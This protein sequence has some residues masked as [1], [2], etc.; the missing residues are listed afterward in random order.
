MR[1]PRT[2][3]KHDDSTE[4]VFTDAKRELPPVMAPNPTSAGMTCGR[5]GSKNEFRLRE[6]TMDF[7]RSLLRY[8]ISIMV[9]AIA[10]ILLAAPALSHAQGLA[11]ING[12]VTDPTGAVIPGAQAVLTDTA[13]SKVSHAASNGSGEYTFPALPP[14]N[15]T[16]K[17]TAAGFNGYTQANIHLEADQAVTINATLKPGSGGETVEVTAAPPQVDVTTGTLSQVISNHQ[18]NELPIN[19][20]NAASLTTLAAGVTTAPSGASDQGNTKTFPVV[21]NISVNGTRA[22]QT[23]YL[24]DGGNNLDEYTNVNAPFPFPDALQEFSIQT[25]NFAAEYGQSAGGV[26][27]IITKS[28]TSAYHGNVFEYVRNAVFNAHNYFSF[29]TNSN[30]TLVPYVDPLKRNQFGGTFGG[31]VGI[32]H[33]WKLN[34]GFFF[35]GYQ[36]TSIRDQAATVATST[37]PTTANTAGQFTFT[38]S[39]A[40][41]AANSCI[42]DPFTA[43]NPCF[44]Y[45]FSSGTTYTSTIPTSRFD[46]ASLKMLHYI[47]VTGSTAFAFK[48]PTSQDMDEGVGRYDQDLGDHDHLAA[49]YFLDK[50]HNQGVLDLTNLLTYADTSD[51]TYQNALVSEDHTFTPHV[52]NNLILSYQRE[53]AVRGPAGNGIDV[54]DFGV[55]IWQPANKSIQNIGVS[56]YFSIGDNPYAVFKRSN[57]TLADDVHWVK[58][59]HSF[60]FG[61]HGELGRVD[62]VNQNGQPGTFSFNAN[63]T[64]SAIASFF[65]G[66]VYETKQSS[67]QYQQNRGKYFG[68]YAQD[69]WK[70]N[71]RLTLDY[72]LRWEPYIPLHEGGGRVGQFNPTAY[73]ANQHS[74]IYPNAPAGLL[75]RGDAGVP[76]DGIRSVY[77]NF[78]PRLGFAWDVF[79][80]GTTSLRGGAGMFYDTRSDGLFNNGWI[81]ST[82]FSTSV[83]LIQQAGATFSNPYG[84]QASPF[85]APFPPPKNTPFI[86]PFAV[87]TFDPSGN[88]QVPLTYAW[89]L[90]GEQQFT[91]TLSG[92]LAY[93]GVHA[94]HVFTSP[95][96]NPAV[97]CNCTT[98][99]NSRRLYQNYTTISET[100]VGGNSTYHSLQFT[101][102]ERMK[103]GM[104]GAINYTWSKSLDTVPVGTAVTSAGAGISYVLPVYMPHFKTLDTGPSDFDHRNLLSA[105]Y[106][107]NIPAWRGGNAIA[108]YIVNGWQ[109]NGIFTL[110]S[111]DAL[112]VQTGKDVSNTGLNRDVPLLVGTHDNAIGGNACGT[113]ALCRN[114]FNPASFVAAAAGQFGNVKKGSFVGPRY[115]DWD[116]SLA[117][118]FPI[119]ESVGLQF[120][121]EYFNVLN[122]TNL[123]DPATSLSSAT[124]GRITSANDPRIAQLA[125]KLAF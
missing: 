42:K 108:R 64:N 59:A 29:V 73:A 110:R 114:Y 70:L 53:G 13:T 69:T 18:I 107:W 28:G 27:N 1:T 76:E 88:F 115:I 118:N 83:D 111:G 92:R 105:N 100:N 52:I 7:Y 21:V 17:V 5:A 101:L 79:G 55:N 10:T 16:L 48:K 22:N 123:S 113:V 94:S 44:P 37:L 109:T 103:Y 54:S 2:G 56:G 63:V 43:G 95:E 50:F 80:H 58:G 38:A 57:V 81:G 45:V 68:L 119:H 31:P 87:I 125:L 11:R 46:Q 36:H 26:V 116:A 35:A 12:T 124:F 66:Y 61:F 32:P 75:F 8:R 117:R 89:N 86:L 74:V 84:T 23:N 85:P 71:P 33:L 47:P 102:R 122:Y 112:S 34:R 120:R 72:G 51:I 40:T 25:S 121:A 24:L 4:R 15:Y 60:G 30:G 41:A 104:S 67:G 78:M 9:M 106:V 90:A 77:G 97:A 91:S 20:R 49:R 99:V 82:P 93:V 65:L 6:L 39:S 96:L 3:R 19:S 98:T 14:A 62:V